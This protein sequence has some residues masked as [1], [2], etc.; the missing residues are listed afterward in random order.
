LLVEGLKSKEKWG[1]ENG[2]VEKNFEQ[3]KTPVQ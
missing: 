3:K 1:R 2:N